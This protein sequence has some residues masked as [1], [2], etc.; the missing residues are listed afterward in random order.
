MFSRYPISNS[1]NFYIFL[2]FLT[3]EAYSREVQNNW[4]IQDITILSVWDIFLNSTKNQNAGLTI[5]CWKS[6]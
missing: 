6:C 5:C 2:Y 3:D 1:Q 4:Q